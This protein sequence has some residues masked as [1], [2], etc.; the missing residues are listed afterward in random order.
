MDVGTVLVCLLCAWCVF[1]WVKARRAASGDNR[2]PPGV[3]ERPAI[4]QMSMTEYDAAMAALRS[5]AS[6]YHASFQ[7]FH[8]GKC[9]SRSVL[10]SMYALR[11]EALGHMYQL[12]MRMPNDLEAEVQVTQYIEDVDAILR[13]AL[14]DVQERCGAGRLLHPGP[15]DDFY[16]RQWFRAHNDVVE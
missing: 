1:M 2:L 7:H 12:R 8:H 10:L 16:Y 5:F 14:R 13:A 3:E 9:S 15:L 6:E 4:R 11:D